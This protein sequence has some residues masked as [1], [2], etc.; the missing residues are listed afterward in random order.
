M[1]IRRMQALKSILSY[2]ITTR[3]FGKPINQI[4]NQRRYRRSARVVQS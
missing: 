1:S 4:I 3:S 2:N